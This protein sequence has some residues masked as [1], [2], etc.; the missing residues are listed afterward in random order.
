MFSPEE[1]ALNNQPLTADQVAEETKKELQAYG[2]QYKLRGLEGRV[3]RG[4]DPAGML[5]VKVTRQKLEKVAE[6][7]GA[8]VEDVIT[9]TNELHTGA[10]WKYA[11]LLAKADRPDI[12]TWMVAGEVTTNGKEKEGDLTPEEFVKDL[13]RVNQFLDQAVENPKEFFEQAKEN[14]I[15]K[16]KTQFT[17]EDGVPVS[18]LDSGFLA[19]A[20]NGYKSGIVVD[21]GGLLFVG[22]NELDYGVLESVGLKEVEKEDRGRMSTFYVDSEGKDVVKK[23]YSGFAIVLTGDKNVA[24]RLAKTGEEKAQAK[25]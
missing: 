19:M 24:R 7:L 1:P 22:A 15:T 20:V 4:L 2:E 9:V 10:I 23:L 6:K 5:A 18:E 21:K 25:K 12:E 13:E 3:E 8:S 11:D 14:L 16:S 17:V